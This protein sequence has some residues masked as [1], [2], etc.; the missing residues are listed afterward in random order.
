MIAAKSA[1]VFAPKGH[2]G[3]AGAAGG[4]VELA[5]SV[6]AFQRGQLPGTMNYRTPDPN[7]PI[8]VHTGPPRKVIKPYVL[9]TGFTDRGQCTA[10]VIRK[11]VPSTNNH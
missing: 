11:Y 3:N 10:V 9:K 7:C 6:L 2:F 1:S 8:A 4:L 5:A